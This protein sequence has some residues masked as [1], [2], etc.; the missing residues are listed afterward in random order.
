MRSEKRIRCFLKPYWSN[1]SS[2]NIIREL[3]E[4]ADQEARDEIERLIAGEAPEKPIHE[5]ITYEDIHESSDNLW[6]FLY[7]TGYLTSRDLN[8]EIK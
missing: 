4:N 6:N 7:F 8:S 5:E 3:V 2:N 1:T